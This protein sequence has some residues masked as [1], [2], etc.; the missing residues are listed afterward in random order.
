MIFSQFCQGRIQSLGRGSKIFL[1]H[2]CIRDSRSPSPRKE[3][4]GSRSRSRSRSRPRSRSRSRSVPRPRS[5]SRSRGRLVIVSYVRLLLQL[6][7]ISLRTLCIGLHANLRLVIYPFQVEVKKPWKVSY[8]FS[9]SSKV[10][11]F[12]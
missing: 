12:L 9:S 6:L 10:P 7:C 11:I 8:C 3:L 2:F 1:T 5:R 4:S